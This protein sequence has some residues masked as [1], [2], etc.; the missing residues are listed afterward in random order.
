MNDSKPQSPI[1]LD[2]RINPPSIGVDND[3][4]ELSVLCRLTDD[5]L[6]ALPFRHLDLVII[7]VGGPAAADDERLRNWLAGALENPALEERFIVAD[8]QPSEKDGLIS[9]ALGSREADFGQ[10]LLRGANLLADRGRVGAAGRV[11]AWVGPGM[12]LSTEPLLEA[13][14][15]LGE[16]NAGVE[17]VCTDSM[18]DMRLLTQVGNLAGGE[19]VHDD[20]PGGLEATLDRRLALLR[21]QRLSTLRLSLRFEPMIK[22][23]RFF[24][25]EP[26]A[27]LVRDLHMNEAL[28]SVDIDLGPMSGDSPLPSYLLTVLAPRRPGDDTTLFTL[29]LSA[30]DEGVEW[31]TAVSQAPITPGGIPVDGEVNSA[32]EKVSAIRIIEDIAHAYS[33]EDGG[34]IAMLLEHL[35]RHYT[36]LG[37]DNVAVEL[38]EMKLKFLR[39]GLWGRANLNEIRR[40]AC[41]Y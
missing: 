39:G 15:L 1:R 41:K 17:L 11:L 35:I 16:L 29:G 21:T 24:R 40:L 3:L 18:A 33:R 10:A 7:V 13:I 32:L 38:Y 25:V 36:V 34:R 8:T 4:S 12:T 27:V 5:G 26:G 37:M 20:S 31:S 28:D 19:F 2:W 23:V 14:D 30:R 22:P 9:G 6:N